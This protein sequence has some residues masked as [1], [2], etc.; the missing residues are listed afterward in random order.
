M[1]GLN[2]AARALIRAKNVPDALDAEFSAAY[3]LVAQGERGVIGVGC[4]DGSEIK[5]VYVDPGAQGS[6]AG[7]ALMEALEREAAR[8][9]IREVTVDSSSSAQ[10][11]Y[12]RLGYQT[13]EPL[14]FKRGDA[15]FQFTRMVKRLRTQAD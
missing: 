5:R 12:A 10:R 13:V 6:G 14:S 1:D 2:G 11:F 7:K 3:P 9:G 4:L 8:R 15:E